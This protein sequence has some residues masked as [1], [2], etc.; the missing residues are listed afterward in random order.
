M[1]FISELNQDLD[2]AE[3]EIEEQQMINSDLKVEN[4][5][6]IQ[7]VKEQGEKDQK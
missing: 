4:L 2:N 7:M 3:T 6:L 5:N 1:N